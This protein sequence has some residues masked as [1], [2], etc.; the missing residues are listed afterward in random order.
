MSGSSEFSD[1]RC[2]NPCIAGGG[3]PHD[4]PVLGQLLL[5]LNGWEKGKTPLRVPKGHLGAAEQTLGLFCAFSCPHRG[6]L[7]CP[8][9]GTAT[10]TLCL[11]WGNNDPFFLFLFPQKNKIK[12][13]TEKKKNQP[14]RTQ[15]KIR[16]IICDGSAILHQNIV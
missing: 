4:A 12:P 6:C 2:C 10:T 5:P 3:R 14:T 8:P 9:G 16:K 11:R 13:Q 7:L 1:S 15:A